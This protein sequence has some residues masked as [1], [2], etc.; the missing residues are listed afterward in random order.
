M[1][2]TFFRTAL[3]DDKETEIEV[4]IQVHTWGCAAHM[5]SMSYAGHPAEGPE[6]EIIDAW[7]LADADNANAPRILDKLTDAERERIEVEFCEN[8][9]EPDYGDDY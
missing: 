8:P 9:P 2:E 6:V 5:G 1:S 4:E 7:L 3:L